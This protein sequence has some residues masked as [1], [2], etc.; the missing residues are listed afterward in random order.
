[1]FEFDTIIV[2]SQKY[3]FFLIF[4]A[5][6]TSTF[7][8]SSKWLQQQHYHYFDHSWKHVVLTW[9]CHQQSVPII[10]GWRSK[11]KLLTFWIL[12]WILI[13]HHSFSCNCFCSNSV[14][15]HSSFPSTYSRGIHYSNYQ[16][17]WR[18]KR[19]SLSSIFIFWLPKYH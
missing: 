4:A 16:K 1:M 14:L 13:G 15:C 2:V 11:R 19:N 8:P 10:C 5:S 6:A 18:T 3:N 7:S 9:I 17:I 12:I